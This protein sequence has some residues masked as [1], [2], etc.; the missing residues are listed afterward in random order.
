[1]ADNPAILAVQ[2]LR[3]VFPELLLACDVCLCPYTDHGHCGGVAWDH[4]MCYTLFCVS[5]CVCT[6]FCV[7]VCVCACVCVSVSVGILYEDGSINNAQSIKRL[8]EV[9]VAYAKAG[10]LIITV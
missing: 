9:A 7:C 1:M 3:Q 6:A 2:K 5:P 4:S 8:A 10:I